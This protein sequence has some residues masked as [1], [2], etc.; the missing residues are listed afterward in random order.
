MAHAS[1]TI[2]RATH[3]SR[4]Q[5]VDLD[6]GLSASQRA[7]ATAFCV[8]I[9]AKLHPAIAHTTWCEAEAFARHTRAA[10]GRSLPFPL[11]YWIPRSQRKAVLQHFAGASASEVYQGAAEALDAL[12]QRLA[13]A[14]FFFGAQPTSVD[15][16]LFSCLAYLR[17]APVVH[18]QLRHKLEGHRV[19]GAYVERLSQLAFATS[20]PAAADVRLGEGAWSSSRGAD[21]K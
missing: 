9:E 7:E 12:A 14:D 15:A 21:D 3:T 8:L 20:A 4:P 5:V 17:I 13:G 6:R 10:Y 11:S 19:L 2:T 1:A 16:L 18:P